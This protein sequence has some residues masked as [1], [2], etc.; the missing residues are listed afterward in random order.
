MAKTIV[1]QVVLLFAV[2]TLPCALSQTEEEV[3][4]KV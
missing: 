3:T 4:T 1:F 2:A